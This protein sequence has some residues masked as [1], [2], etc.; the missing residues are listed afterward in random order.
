MEG[1]EFVVKVEYLI[2]FFLPFFL[3]FPTSVISPDECMG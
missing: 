1:V 3:S 2:L